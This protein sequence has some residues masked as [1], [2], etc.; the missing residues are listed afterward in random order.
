MMW[1]DHDIFDGWGSFPKSSSMANWSRPLSMSAA[2][3][4][5]FQLGAT[6]ETAPGREGI[7]PTPKALPRSSASR[8]SQWLRPTF[9]LSA[10]RLG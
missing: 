6:D 8:G 3:F 10:G 7:E 9:A 4:M 2:M 1:D 5:L